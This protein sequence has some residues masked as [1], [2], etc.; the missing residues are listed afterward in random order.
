MDS[1]SGARVL[2][3]GASGFIGSHLTR[4]LVDDGAE[5]HALTSAVS[6]VY[7]T[8]LVDLREDIVLHEGN[9]NDQ[10][11]MRALA[12]VVRPEY[13]FHL[14]AYTH[15]GKSWER[16]DECTQ[17]N[18]V[19]TVNLLRAIEDT[20]YRR[21]VFTGT[22]EIYGAVEVPFR[23]DAAVE[24]GSPYAVSKYAAERF[25]RMLHR[26]RGWPI[27]LLRPF[28]AYGPAQ[29]PDRVI[30]EVIVRALEGR[31]L[32]MTSGTQTR[33]FNYVVDLVDGFVRAALTPGIE[34]E[35]LNLGCGEEIAVAELAT[36]ILGLMGDPIEVSIGAL[37]ERPNE[38]P[39][40]CSDSSK[41]RE[42]LGWKPA[43]TLDDGLGRTIE[44]Y[45]RELKSPNSSFV[46]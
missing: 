28:N 22:S 38:I 9:L 12:R 1:L 29:S 14:G 34:G 2:V 45:E 31:A 44:W 46:T 16:I 5:V 24:P 41:A 18:V 4:R 27:V 33:E 11:A 13:V 20:G 32:Q 43:H 30:P 39:R 36:K 40:M 10:G 26:G 21:M 42:L 23:E 3:T 7:P 19:G 15:V 6:S 25:C 37:P 17:T 35:L 8:R